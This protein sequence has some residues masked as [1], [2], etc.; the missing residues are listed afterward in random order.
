MLI[1]NILYLLT[2]CTSIN[3]FGLAAWYKIETKFNPIPIKTPI[4]KGRIKHAKKVAKPG[5]RSLSKNKN[6]TYTNCIK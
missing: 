6:Q 4:S 5:I 1:I 3:S 2:L